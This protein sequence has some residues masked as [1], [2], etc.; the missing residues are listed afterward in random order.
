VEFPC[1]F[2]DCIC[3]EREI[4]EWVR[5]MEKR[6]KEVLLY[7]KKEYIDNRLD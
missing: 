3:V 1:F 2:F 7:F 4:M 5:E 6:K